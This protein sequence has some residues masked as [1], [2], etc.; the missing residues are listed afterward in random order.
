MTQRT[1]FECE[2]G[3]A[4]ETDAG[5]R[6]TITEGC[7]PWFNSSMWARFSRA[8]AAE[9]SHLQRSKSLLREILDDLDQ[10]F[11]EC[12]EIPEP[13]LPDFLMCGERKSKG[14]I[15][16]AKEFK[17]LQQENAEL[18]ELLAACKDD[19]PCN[20]DHLNLCQTH[21]HFSKPCPHERAT[22]LLAQEPT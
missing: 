9:V 4:E 17:E 5:I 16:L 10:V 19:V 21:W 12:K 13:I 6:V 8:L 22:D 20:Y 1:I 15:K 3:K 14:V 2:H 18:R 11:Q 7:P